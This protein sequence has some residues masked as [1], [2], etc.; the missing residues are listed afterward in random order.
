M[1]CVTNMSK[2]TAG[3]TSLNGFAYDAAGCVTRIERDEK[4]TLDLTWNGRYQLVSVS[5]NGVFAESY[6]YDALGRRV[7]TT[8]Q[9]GTLRHVYDNG[10][11][12]IAD[13]D[14]QTNMVASYT[15]SEGIDKLLAVTVGGAT[16]YPLTKGLG[17]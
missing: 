5:T 13:I 17:V 6:T 3:G 4:P 15:W 12:V 7:S 2:T 1:D 10:W 16:Y 9:E 11:Q 14:E 8:T